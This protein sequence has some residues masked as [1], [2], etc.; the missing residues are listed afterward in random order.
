[1]S[2]IW[3]NKLVPSGGTYLCSMQGYMC[4]IVTLGGKSPP[5]RIRNQVEK[6]IKYGSAWLDMRHAR[7][8][9]LKLKVREGDIRLN[10][11]GKAHDN[12]I[13]T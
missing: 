2:V 9:C 1:M 5:G 12:A 8:I 11:S 6:D 3:E 4:R 7:A 10:E 13:T